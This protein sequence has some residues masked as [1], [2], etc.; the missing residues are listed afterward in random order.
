MIKQ[1]AEKG[2]YDWDNCMRLIGSIVEVIQQVQAPKRDE[3]T[4]LR[5]RQIAKSMEESEDVEQ[6][7]S[8]CKALEFLLDRVNAMRI[9]TANAW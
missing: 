7:R 9:D 2:L 3:E 5:F 6:P 8:F 4:K 1:Q